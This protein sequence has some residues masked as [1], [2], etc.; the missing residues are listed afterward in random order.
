MS[1]SFFFKPTTSYHVNKIIMAFKNK[2]S[3]N[4]TFPTKII[5]SISAIISPTL[6]WLMNISISSD[7]FSSS[8]NSPVPLCNNCANES[9]VMKIGTDVANYILIDILNGGKNYGNSNPW[10]KKITINLSNCLKNQNFK[11]I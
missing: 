2:T 5:K 8:F 4:N 6:T 10:K 3:N 7:R 9:K 11:F 1:N